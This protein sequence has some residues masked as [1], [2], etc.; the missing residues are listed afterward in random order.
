[1]TTTDLMGIPVSLDCDAHDH[2]S[3]LAAAQANPAE[4]Q[5]VYLNTLAVW[6][7]HTY[8]QWLGIDT[9]PSE[10]DSWQPGLAALLDVA[11]LPIVGMGRLECRPVLPGERSFRLPLAAMGD[12]LGC[13]A[14]QFFDTLDRVELVGFLPPLPAES[15]VDEPITIAIEDLLPLIALLN[16][17]HPVA[18]LRQWLEGLLDGPTWQAPEQLLA[19]TRYRPTPAAAR[20][21]CQAKSIALGESGQ[22]TV[23]L[24]VQVSAETAAVEQLTVRLRVYPASSKALLPRLRVAVLDEWGDVLLE[25]QTQP[26]AVYTELVLADCQPGEQFSVRMTYRSLSVVE[27]FMV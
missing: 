14:V 27:E 19:T 1:M 3:R 26:D 17:L 16:A 20:S 11:D 2:A 6:A 25:N 5:R 21:V 24:V 8:C 9:A 10:G 22:P 15:A 23:V 7:V 12:R 18:N 13:V 4:G